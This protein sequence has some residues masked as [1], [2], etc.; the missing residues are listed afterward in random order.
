MS[1]RARLTSFFV[2]IVVVPMVA[3]GFL[4]FRLISDSENGKADARASGLASA[5]TSLYESD[6][7]AA[8]ADAG[9]I[10]RD[11]ALLRPATRRQRLSAL[12]AS[13]GLARATATQG[14]TTLADIGDKTAVAAGAA[15]INRA[16]SQPLTITVSE[17]TATAYARG[18]SGPGVEIA[19]AQD[20]RTLATT[21]AGAH[22]RGFPSRGPLPF[23]G[24]ATGR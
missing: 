13:A 23:T 18:L 19:V 4:G 15:A 9:T 7:A 20:G 8:R 12:A 10:A 11:S 6:A 21:T 17:T 3:I 24:V 22:G 1:F 16:G 2:L 5:A 14:S